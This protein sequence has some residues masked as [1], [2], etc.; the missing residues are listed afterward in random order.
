MVSAANYIGVFYYRYTF[1]YFQD[2]TID[3]LLKIDFFI[4]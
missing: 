2:A 4:K 3:I 1:V